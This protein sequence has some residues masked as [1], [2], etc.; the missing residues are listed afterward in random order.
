MG[1]RRSLGRGC[2][3][4][5]KI[6]VIKIAHSQ[7]DSDRYASVFEASEMKIMRKIFVNFKLI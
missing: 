2:V 6:M 5:I 7:K 3:C 4:R 1:V